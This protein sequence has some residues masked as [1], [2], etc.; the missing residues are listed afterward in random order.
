MP[1]RIITALNRTLRL[2]L[3]ETGHVH[4]GSVGAV[5]VCHDPACEAR[6][7]AQADG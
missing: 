5:A 4:T 7:T 3:S 1:T 6:R 2:L